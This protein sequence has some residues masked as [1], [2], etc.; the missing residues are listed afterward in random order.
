MLKL[1]KQNKLYFETYHNTLAQQ[2]PSLNLDSGM[3][4]YDVCGFEVIDLKNILYLEEI[5]FY[6]QH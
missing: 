5:P 1:P 3:S 2:N 6:R 4:S